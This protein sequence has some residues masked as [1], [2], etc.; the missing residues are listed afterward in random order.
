MGCFPPNGTVTVEVSGSVTDD[1]EKK[2]EKKEE[3][4]VEEVKT[5]EVKEEVITK[6]EVKTSETKEVKQVSYSETKTTTVVKEESSSSEVVASSQEQEAWMVEVDF[7]VELEDFDN[8]KC[9]E[10][11]LS[12]WFKKGE[13]KVE[14][15]LKRIELGEKGKIRINGKDEHGDYKLKGKINHDGSV[16]LEKKYET[17]EKVFKFKGQINDKGD[18]E[19]KWMGKHD[20]KGGE[21]LIQLGFTKK[22]TEDV[23]KG[24]VGLVEGPPSVGLMKYKDGWGVIRE[25]KEGEF[26]IMYAK[27]WK[28][29]LNFNPNEGYFILEDWTFT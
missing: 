11:P 22:L 27:G 9:V 18:I 25:V 12:G 26:E 7:A 5:Q 3:K 28:K 4:K 1:K 17:S 13:E 20:N 29:S 10:V 24:F 19:G 15:D 16:L 21:F 6:E 8:D 2:E 14:M 23:H